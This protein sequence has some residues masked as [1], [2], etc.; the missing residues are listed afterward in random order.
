MGAWNQTLIH[1]ELWGLGKKPNPWEIVGFGGKKNPPERFGGNKTPSM[2]LSR[3]LGSPNTIPGTGG[4]E[5]PKLLPE[6]AQKLRECPEPDPS[7]ADLG[8]G[9]RGSGGSS[10][11]LRQERGKGRE[12]ALPAW[13]SHICHARIPRQL[14][15][16]APGTSR[17]FGCGV[18][19]GK[20]RK[21]LLKKKKENRAKNSWERPEG[22][23]CSNRGFGGDREGC[24]GRRAV[25]GG[26]GCS[27]CLGYL[28][29]WRCSGFWDVWGAQDT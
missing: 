14:P 3:A 17:G 7:G 21:I 2:G 23:K 4:G 18:E 15:G 5:N 27:G 16:E 9:V 12:K 24:G 13:I 19:M 11:K 22:P 28:G 29:C 10:K 1:G 6:N 26:L 20:G 8:W 25:L